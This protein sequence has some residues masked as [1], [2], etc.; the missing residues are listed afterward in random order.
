MKKIIFIVF[1]TTFVLGFLA[2]AAM[3]PKTEINFVE[4][5]V[6]VASGKYAGCHDLVYGKGRPLLHESVMELCFHK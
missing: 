1:T 3:L 2:R 5:D 4:G 6:V